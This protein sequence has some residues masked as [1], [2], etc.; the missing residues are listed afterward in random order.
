MTARRL[1]GML[2]PSSN[3]VLEPVTAAMLAAIPEASAHFSRFRVTEI[4]LSSSALAQFDDTEILRA[5]ELLAH[6]RVDVIG[7]NGT[8]AGWL[9]FGADE[10]LCRRIAE[11]TGIPAC[12]SV[13]ALNEILRRMQARRI[14]LVTPYVE[15]VQQKIIG[16]Y[17]ATGFDTVSERHL[18]WSDNWSFSTAS[19][20]QLRKMIVAVASARPDAIV[21][22]CTGLR[23]APLVEGLERE[24]GIPILD[25]VATVVWKSLQLAGVDTRRV[26]GWGRLF[27]D[28]V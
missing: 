15:E 17:A 21:V 10:R 27:R 11:A 12:T 16:N 23:A 13:L 6:A 20:D 3:T 24:I 2:T 5:A 26:T 8:S 7:W 22:L 25:S 28:L 18:G 1:L 4:G 19:S 14:A 9:G